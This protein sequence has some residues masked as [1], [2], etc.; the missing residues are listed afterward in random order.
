MRT[1]KL[2]LHG[3]LFPQVLAFRSLSFSYIIRNH[4]YSLPQLFSSDDGSH[5]A[6]TETEGKYELDDLRPPSVSFTRNSILFGENPPTQRNNGPLWLWRGAKSTLPPFVTGAWDEGKGDA[7]PAEHLYNL[8]FVR[9]PTFFMGLLY[10]RNLSVGHPLV[11][12]YGD[13]FFE[14]PSLLVFCVFLVILR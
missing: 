2:L 11:M 12:N 4:R 9:M 10:I 1:Y 3:L 6:V 13:G 7:K 14:V 5:P 8:L